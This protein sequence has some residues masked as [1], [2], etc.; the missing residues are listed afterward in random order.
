MKEQKLTRTKESKRARKK[1][2]NRQRQTERKKGLVDPLG[3]KLV[4]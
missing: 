3:T 2:T 1:Q 4:N